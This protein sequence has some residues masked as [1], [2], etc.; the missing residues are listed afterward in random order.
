MKT[1]QTLIKEIEVRSNLK[2]FDWNNAS[3]RFRLWS[4]IDRELEKLYEIEKILNRK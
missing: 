2:K 3:H 4:K 1:T